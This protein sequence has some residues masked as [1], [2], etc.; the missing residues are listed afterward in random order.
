M[1]FVFALLFGI[2]VVCVIF[3]VVACCLRDGRPLK[4]LLQQAVLPMI[5][6]NVITATIISLT[7]WR[8]GELF[9]SFWGGFFQVVLFL[10]GCV[11]GLLASL[12]ALCNEL[13]DSGSAYAEDGYY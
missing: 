4:E 6:P 1:S 13:D 11:V 12:I 5:W 8:F 10:V 3:L 9:G 7:G 2:L